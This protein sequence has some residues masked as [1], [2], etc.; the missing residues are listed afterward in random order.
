MGVVEDLTPVQQAAK[1]RVEAQGKTFV[2]PSK[3]RNRK[4]VKTQPNHVASYTARKARVDQ[5]NELSPEADNVIE[6]ILDPESTSMITR[7]P[8]TYG[9][10]ATYKCK[11]IINAQFDA[12]G[13]SSVQVYPRMRAC[14]SAT[15]GT[16]LNSPLPIRTA[17]QQIPASAQ[18]L[19]MLA[20]Q[21]I[22]HVQPI[23][24]PDRH[25][26]LPLPNSG[27][28]DM[29]YPFG[30]SQISTA[31]EYF[32]EFDYPN[33]ASGQ[34]QVTVTFYDA[35]KNVIVEKSAT[36]V[37]VGQNRFLAALIT[38]NINEGNP[39][40]ISIKHESIGAPYA[41]PALFLTYCSSNNVGAMA[42][43]LANLSQHHVVYDLRDS[44]SIVNNA[45]RFFVAAQS[46]LIT[47]EM[48]SIN[49][50][51]IIATARI[52]GGS[53]VGDKTG[54][55]TSSSWYEWISSLPNNSYDGPVKDGAYSFYVG[56]D[57]RSY[58]YQPV[59]KL[60]GNDLPYM[61]AEFTAADTTEASIVRIKVCTIVQFT[62]NSSI[63]QCGPSPMI[64]ELARIHQLLSVIQSSYSNDG[65]RP[66]LKRALKKASQGVVKM[67]KNPKTY[68]TAA[69]IASAMMLLI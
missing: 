48:S 26:A 15:A 41:G 49:D 42:Y 55:L 32:L 33:A 2:A 6:Q 23:I 54:D 34:M 25:V 29:I 9:L 4:P 40:Y 68:K 20:G 64:P 44:D 39:V 50:G 19:S 12:Y 13:R 46:L 11:N 63:Y 61:V 5:F 30:Y 53:H 66:G 7:W 47:S 65:H 18:E 24:C 21:T 17:S 52:P 58:F 14:I 37:T 10:S 56:D 22:D 31:G 27:N 69:E 35:S 43:T 45:E 28:N 59:A 60:V 67:M 36:N 38:M 1:E 16:V 8:N 57:E 62:T 51:G 3:Y